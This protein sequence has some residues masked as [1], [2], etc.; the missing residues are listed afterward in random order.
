MADTD[1]VVIVEG[2]QELKDMIAQ[3][4]E[5]VMPIA[6]EA[7][8]NS[9]RAIYAIVQPYPDETIANSPQNP[10]G[11]WYERHYGPRWIRKGRMSTSGL[12]T[13]ALSTRKRVNIYEGAGLVGGSPTSEQLQLRWRVVEA[14]P[15]DDKSAIE[16]ELDNTASYALFVQGPLEIQTDVMKGIGWTSI[17]DGI[18]DA[19]DEIDRLWDIF[20]QNAVDVLAGG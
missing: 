9:L 7:I 18:A 2:M 10:K 15:T 1:P 13:S 16:G 12:G 19:A 11:R 4:P 8:D 5:L 20:T 14:A 3:A 6:Q 17:D